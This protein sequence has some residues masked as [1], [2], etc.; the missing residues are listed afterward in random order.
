MKIDDIIEEWKKDAP[1]DQTE[2][3]QESLQTPVLH[4]KYLNYYSDEKLRLKSLY[5]QRKKTRQKL[6]E[7]YRGELNNPEDLKK[8]NREPYPKTV[9]KNEL[10]DVVEA[11]G[12]MERL[13]AK[14]SYVEEVV[15]VLKEI[16]KA[17]DKRGFH[18]KNAIDWYRFTNPV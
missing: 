17:I 3:G 8:M 6:R 9:L 7:Y 5:I 15:E 18:V 2:L 1:I 16:L 4:G 10:D 13:Q 12:E 14:I 11:D